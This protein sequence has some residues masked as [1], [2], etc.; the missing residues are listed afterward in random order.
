MHRFDMKV[1]HAAV[2]EERR[3]RSLS[4]VELAAEINK[5]FEHTTS[6]PISAGTLRDM[7]KKTSVTSAVVLQALRWL[8]RSPESFLSGRAGSARTDEKLPVS[9]PNRILRFD[10]QAMHAALDEKRR[11][12]GM[13]WK[14]V[15]GELPG[16]TPNMLT[17]LANGPLIGFPRVMMIPQ[18]LKCPAAS[19]V[20]SRDR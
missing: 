6:I 11:R 13:T 10:T 2:D 4:W 9:G 17:N 20:R 12:D 18:W 8:G 19:F 3:A 7:P 15:A 14:Q 1:F 16:F 5:P